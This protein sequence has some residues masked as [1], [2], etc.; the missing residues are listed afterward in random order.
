[1]SHVLKGLMSHVSCLSCAITG[2][3]TGL[4]PDLRLC[5]IRGDIPPCCDLPIGNLTGIQVRIEYKAVCL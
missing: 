2:L 3:R 1:M 5:Y 4:L